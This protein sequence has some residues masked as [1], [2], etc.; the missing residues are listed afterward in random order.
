MLVNRALE[1]HM[2]LELTSIG[3]TMQGGGENSFGSRRNRNPLRNLL[4]AGEN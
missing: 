4:K 3:W 1:Q 2:I